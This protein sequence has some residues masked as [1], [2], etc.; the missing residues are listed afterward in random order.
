MRGHPNS[1]RYLSTSAV[2]WC[3]LPTDTLPEER[4]FNVA[5]GHFLPDVSL[6]A[7][8]IGNVPFT[9]REAQHHGFKIYETPF[10]N[11]MKEF[12]LEV[13]FDDLY[14]LKEVRY[15]RS[16]QQL[17]GG[18]RAVPFQNIAWL[19]LTN[20]CCSVIKVS[21]SLSSPELRLEA[22]MAP[23]CS[24]SVSGRHAASSVIRRYG[25]WLHLVSVSMANVQAHAQQE[26]VCQISIKCYPLIQKCLGKINQLLQSCKH[27]LP[28]SSKS[29]TYCLCTAIWP[30]AQ[31]MHHANTYRQIWVILNVIW[32][33]FRPFLI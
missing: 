16:L 23:P 33:S 21:M 1:L 9:L 29:W 11:G 20:N 32:L 24:P 14:V 8:A 18:G 25:I 4:L 19:L 13:S 28:T 2:I 3:S 7:I 31:A 5:F 12:I 30:L 22:C 27:Q 6:V 17:S 26:E 10:S 15:S